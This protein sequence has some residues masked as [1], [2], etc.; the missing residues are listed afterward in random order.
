MNL[1]YWNAYAESEVTGAG[2]SKRFLGE[3]STTVGALQ[4][5]A[6]AKAIVKWPGGIGWK[7]IVKRADIRARN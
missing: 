7:L 2:S 6:R 3:V 4:S 5:V 1:Q